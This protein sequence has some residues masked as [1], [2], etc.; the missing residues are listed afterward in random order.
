MSSVFGWILKAPLLHCFAKFSLVLK[1]LNKL[2]LSNLVIELTVPT[3]PV[4]VKMLFA[5]P[6]GES[7][8]V[9][10]PGLNLLC[11]L[12]WKQLDVKHWLSSAGTGV[13]P[14]K[15][16]VGVDHTQDEILCTPMIC[17]CVCHNIGFCI[18]RNI[19]GFL[20]F[21]QLQEWLLLYCFKRL[22]DFFHKASSRPFS[23]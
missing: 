9:Q 13:R 4:A 6:C 7:E 18:C 12:S 23:K 8:V 16:S 19:A 2:S 10:V 11:L 17:I 20:V 15:N 3:L 14:S 22:R 5:S 21:F 1:K